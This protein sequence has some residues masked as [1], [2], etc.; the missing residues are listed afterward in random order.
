MP[1]IYEQ[2]WNLSS[3]HVL[4]SRCDATGTPLNPAAD[5]VLDEQAKAGG[6]M[7]IDNAPRLLIPSVRSGLFTEPTFATLITLL[8]HYDVT[9]GVAEKLLSDP[10]HGP[11]VEAFL[12]A[13]LPTPPMLLALNHIK[14]TWEPPSPTPSSARRSRASGL[15][16]SRTT[17]GMWCLTASALNMSSSEKARERRRMDRPTITLVGITLG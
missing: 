6:S 7:L 11:A 9:E 8:D 3:S 10:V 15:N 14:A 5:V 4:V 13:I 1:D 12:D 17:S 16:P 2:I